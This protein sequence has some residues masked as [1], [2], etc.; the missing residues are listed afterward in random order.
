MRLTSA[1]KVRLGGF[2]LVALALIL[3]VVA[4]LTGATLGAQRSLYKVHFHE[5][6][7]GLERSAPVKYQ[8][9]RVGRVESMQIAAAD[10]GAIEVTLAIDPATVLLTGTTASLDAAGIT[11][12]QTVNLKPG[13]RGGARL[14][15][16]TLLEASSSLFGRLTGNADSIIG[17]IRQVTE[18]LARFTSDTNRRRL[19]SLLGN[20]DVF[21][22]HLNEVLLDA[23]GPAVAALRDLNRVADAVVE[24][25]AEATRTLQA[26]QRPVRDIDP[27]EVAG[28]VSAVRRAA[29]QVES[30]LAAPETGRAITSLGDTL[31]R[32]SNLID[33]VD[34][35]VRAGRQDFTA[36]LSYLRQASEDLREFSR[37][38]AQN[39][40]VLVRGR[41]EANE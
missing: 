16:G 25:A 15:P 14:A 5:S 22:S 3:S 4:A 9:L 21:V 34:T 33:D 11:G 36:T 29:S 10:P 28:A 7:G 31:E 6:V 13:P 12:L 8:G 38:L 18:Q 35:A 27:R 30:R 41:G 1:E 26:Y 32:A 20:L 40:S 24:T 39:P 23:P 37:L 19:E 2:V 17:G